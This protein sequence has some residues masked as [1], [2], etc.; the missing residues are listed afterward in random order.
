[1][2]ESMD[3]G[4][5]LERVHLMA[6]RQYDNRNRFKPIGGNIELNQ[7][8][9]ALDIVEDFIVNNFGKE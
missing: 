9:L 2:S 5:A 4:Y 8:K 1:M 7:D 3:I 6:K